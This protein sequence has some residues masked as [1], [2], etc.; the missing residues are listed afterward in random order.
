MLIEHSFQLFYD[1]ELEVGDIG[2]AS[3]T[4]GVG[5]VGGGGGV[6]PPAEFPILLS[7]SF[8]ILLNPSLILSVGDRNI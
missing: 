7:I 4:G 8:L 1:G 5:G 6:V 2:G 3:S